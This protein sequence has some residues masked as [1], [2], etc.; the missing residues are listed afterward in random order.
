MTPSHELAAQGQ[1]PFHRDLP[2]SRS[3]RKGR[4][5]MS[6]RYE[7][8]HRHVEESMT[9]ELLTQFQKGDGADWPLPNGA[10]GHGRFA[11]VRRC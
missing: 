7:S 4:V 1:C 5:R 3:L 8:S 10:D 6:G 9:V 2:R 11:Q